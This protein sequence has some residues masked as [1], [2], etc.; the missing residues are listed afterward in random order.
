MRRYNGL[1]VEIL[2]LLERRGWLRVTEITQATGHRPYALY[3]Y[4][5]GLRRWGL[6]WERR[7]P[8]VEFTISARGR[9][10]LAWLRRRS[11]R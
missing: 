11:P 7:R 3:S 2:A 5:R 8:F 9:E 1:K 10:R 4:L 6:L